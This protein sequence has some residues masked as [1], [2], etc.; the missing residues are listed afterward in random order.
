MG[1][2]LELLGILKSMCLK[3]LVPNTITNE[4]LIIYIQKCIN[5]LVEMRKVKHEIQKNKEIKKFRMNIS[6]SPSRFPAFLPFSFSFFLFIDRGRSHTER[7]K[8]KKAGKGKEKTTRPYYC[9]PYAPL[10]H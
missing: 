2:I 9:Y 10:C 4:A 1:A 3:N 8:K 5:L 7:S 6:I